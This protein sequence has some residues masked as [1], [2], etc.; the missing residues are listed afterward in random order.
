MR[1]EI[2]KKEQ[3]LRRNW[4]KEDR[5]PLY[6]PQIDQDIRNIQEIDEEEVSQ[7]SR[8]IEIDIE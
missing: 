6:I 1:P 2:I 3:D 8:I 7:V 4:Q 5:I